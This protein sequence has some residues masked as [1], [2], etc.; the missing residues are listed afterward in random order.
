VSPR[1]LRSP[2]T[3][4]RM[5]TLSSIVFAVLL[6]A[7][8]VGGAGIP[9]DAPGRVFAA[10]FAIIIAALT[11][12]VWHWFM[13]SWFREYFRLDREYRAIDDGELDLDRTEGHQFRFYHVVD[14][15]LLP[16]GMIY[17]VLLVVHYVQGTC[18]SAWEC[19]EQVSFLGSWFFIIIALG[20]VVERIEKTIRRR[21]RRPPAS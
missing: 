5:V 10:S 21:G 9:P 1:T 6:S 19:L 12:L 18:S 7:V 8:V 17:F 4:R 11:G 20:A 14:L 15:L 16:L 13:G 3:L 2:Q